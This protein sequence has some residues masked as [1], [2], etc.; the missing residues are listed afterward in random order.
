[1]G[2]L[3]DKGPIMRGGRSA[4][5]CQKGHPGEK[6]SCVSWGGFGR[7][8]GGKKKAAASKWARKRARIL[9]KSAR[10]VLRRGGKR[11][12]S[13]YTGREGHSASKIGR[14]RGGRPVA[15]KAGGG[16]DSLVV[17]EGGPCVA[18]HLPGGAGGY[19]IIAG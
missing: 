19:F 9:E 16:L 14:P 11:G 2:G 10:K 5:R 3:A 18:Q 8:L 12:D 15:R 7:L 6:E 1:V 13:Q 17:W 4:A